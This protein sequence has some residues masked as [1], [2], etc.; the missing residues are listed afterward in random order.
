MLVSGMKRMSPLVAAGGRFCENGW[1]L[2]TGKCWTATCQR[3]K[4]LVAPKLCGEAGAP[5]QISGASGF[6]RDQSRSSRIPGDV[7]EI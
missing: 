4:G 7:P 1:K 6:P 2:S 5:L 3:C